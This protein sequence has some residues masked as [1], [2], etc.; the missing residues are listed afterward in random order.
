MQTEKCGVVMLEE[1]K[2]EKVI[3]WERRG[4]WAR[5]IGVSLGFWVLRAV[6]IAWDFLIYYNILIP[7]L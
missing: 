4:E 7:L 1:K 6:T 3:V 2:N 5:G